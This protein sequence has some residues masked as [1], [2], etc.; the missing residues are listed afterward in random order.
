VAAAI[1]PAAA[2]LPQG[3][4]VGARMRL[5]QPLCHAPAARA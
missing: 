4:I 2:E 5:R 1:I 3:M